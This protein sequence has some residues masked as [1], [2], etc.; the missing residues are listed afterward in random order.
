MKLDASVHYPLIQLAVNH[1][2]DFK[3]LFKEFTDIF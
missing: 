1:L 3:R 2:I